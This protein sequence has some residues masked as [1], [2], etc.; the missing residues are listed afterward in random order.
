[1]DDPADKRIHR[2]VPFVLRVAYGGG[3]RA[4]DAT[5]NVSEGGLFIQTDQDFEV[6]EVVPVSLSFPGL[7]DPVE[8]LGIVAWVRASRDGHP[9]GVGIRVEGAAD[10]KRLER[11]VS[12]SAN[13]PQPATQPG[14]SPA[15]RAPY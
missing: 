9:S 7:L 6:G 11:L 3:A 14:E 13:A 4:W 12:M 10:R 15:R 8:I 2:R 1:M 5:E